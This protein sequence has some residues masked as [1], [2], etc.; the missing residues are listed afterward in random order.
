MQTQIEEK[1]ISAVHLCVGLIS[2]YSEVEGVGRG[3]DSGS[4]G[5]T[6]LEAPFY[7]SKISNVGE[8]KLKNASGVMLEM[9]GNAR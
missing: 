2:H 8:N 9:T 5:I 1:R 4:H 6:N 3:E 7:F